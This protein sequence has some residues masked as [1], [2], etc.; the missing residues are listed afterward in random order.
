MSK[1]V[2]KLF[3]LSTLG[4]FKTSAEGP[5]A[6]EQLAQEQARTRESQAQAELLSETTSRKTGRARVVGRELL[7]FAGSQ[8]NGGSGASA[9]P[10]PSPRSSVSRSFTR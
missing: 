5:T 9:R 7:A 2:K 1:T 6:A 4:L 10:S 8:A 3:N